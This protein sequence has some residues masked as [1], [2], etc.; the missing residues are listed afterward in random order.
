MRMLINQAKKIQF[1]QS[2]HPFTS[3]GCNI[4]FSCFR[5]FKREGDGKLTFQNKFI[6]ILKGASKNVIKSKVANAELYEWLKVDKRDL[7]QNDIASPWRREL[8]EDHGNS[9]SAGDSV[10]HRLNPSDL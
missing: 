9:L 3:S 6:R 7:R 2:F 5:P 4:F 10:H 8:L 1:N